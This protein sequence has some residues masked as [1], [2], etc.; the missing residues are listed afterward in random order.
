MLVT[1]RHYGGDT[2]RGEDGHKISTDID[3]Q[4]KHFADAAL[5]LSDAIILQAEL[6]TNV[7]NVSVANTLLADDST[8]RK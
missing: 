8:K 3:D 6:L 1:I 5:Y 7:M 4:L 2:C